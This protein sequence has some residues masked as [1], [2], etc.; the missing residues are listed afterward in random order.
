M[1]F[2]MVHTNL[3]VL[4]L[5]RSLRFYKEA[6]G[7]T[8]ARRSEAKDGS[9]KIVFLSDGTDGL[10]LELTWLGDKDTPYALGDNETHIAFRVREFDE[11]HQKHRDMGVICYENEK[12][13]IYFINDP[14]GYWLEI[15]P[16][17]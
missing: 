2:T 9:Y 1:Q 8:E 17:R 11:A 16:V 3:N 10:K 13:G 12:M 7:L 4:D 14:D 5:D 15:L 6:L